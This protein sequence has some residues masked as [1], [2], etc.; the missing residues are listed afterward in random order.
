M[1]LSVPRMDSHSCSLS[2]QQ[3][4]ADCD[5]ICDTLIGLCAGRFA[6]LRI[7]RN[8][9][10]KYTQGLSNLQQSSD[11]SDDD[12]ATE[13]GFGNQDGVRVANKSFLYPWKEPN[14]GITFRYSLSTENQNPSLTTL[15]SATYYGSPLQHSK[16]KNLAGHVHQLQYSISP[17]SPKH[18]HTD[19]NTSFQLKAQSRRPQA[20]Y[21]I[22]YARPRPKRTLLDLDADCALAAI[23]DKRIQAEEIAEEEARRMADLT[24]YQPANLFRDSSPMELHMIQ[25][26]K[27]NRW[28]ISEWIDSNREAQRP[29]PVQKPK[30]QSEQPQEYY[31]PESR[32]PLRIHPQIDPAENQLWLNVAGGLLDAQKNHRPLAVRQMEMDYIAELRAE[33]HMAHGRMRADADTAEAQMAA[34][35]QMMANAQMAVHARRA[36]DARFAVDAQMEQAHRAAQA[37][38]AR[39]R[40]MEAARAARARIPEPHIETELE[41]Y[42]AELGE[43][44]RLAISQMGESNVPEARKTE[45]ARPADAHNREFPPLE[46][47]K[48]IPFKNPL[49]APQAGL[50]F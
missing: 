41:A 8:R 50:F 12:E 13:V 11:G 22:P 35:A 36:V 43:E 14:F 46:R 25:N 23:E 20:A 45:I 9:A 37:H 29:R 34:E 6:L 39:A 15:S 33:A 28:D 40:K 7:Q 47:S 26:R 49:R 1:A 31:R 42:A 16:D 17:Y 38:M 5:S 44:A 19:S 3:H 24:I 32:V 27:T 18:S 4:L 48:P 30:P 10:L 21:Q 2:F